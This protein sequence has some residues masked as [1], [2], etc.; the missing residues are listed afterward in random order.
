M[1]KDFFWSTF[2]NSGNIQAYIFYKE[3][4][5]LDKVNNENLINKEE[6]DIKI[7]S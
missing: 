4:N 5:E 3:L 7:S 6:A 2:E 1:L